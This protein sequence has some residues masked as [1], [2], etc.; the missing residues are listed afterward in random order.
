MHQTIN[1][2]SIINR[3][4]LVALNNNFS[5]YSV[6]KR[7]AKHI[8]HHASDVVNYKNLF[9]NVILT[10]SEICLFSSHIHVV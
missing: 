9:V 10:E 1:H 8:S 5:F 4:P 3:R 6:L 2:N 7:A